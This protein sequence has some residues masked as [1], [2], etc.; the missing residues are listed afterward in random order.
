[1]IDLFLFGVKPLA[2]RPPTTA[3][4]LV[5]AIASIGMC[6]CS[7]TFSTP[8]C[9]APRAPPPESTRPM[10]GRCG[11]G[12]DEAGSAALWALAMLQHASHRPAK[13]QPRTPRRGRTARGE[14]TGAR[15][16]HVEQETH[17]TG[18]NITRRV[19]ARARADL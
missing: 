19:H 9:A 5:P 13:I 16:Q 15:I 2:Y 14:I 17:T 8:T 11:C 3:P 7:R 10:R 1:M 6:S 4:M 18:C 12:G